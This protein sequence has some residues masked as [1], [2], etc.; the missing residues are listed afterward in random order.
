MML[1]FS[2][3]RTNKAVTN[4][5]YN[6]F[7][8]N[9]FDKVKKNVPL[10]VIDLNFFKDTTFRGQ[11]IGQ[12]FVSDVLK[13]SGV[14]VGFREVSAE[15]LGSKPAQTLLGL[16]WDEDLALGKKKKI[17]KQKFLEHFPDDATKKTKAMIPGFH[18]SDFVS[19]QMHDVLVVDYNNIPNESQTTPVNETKALS[20]QPSGRIISA[21]PAWAIIMKLAKDAVRVRADVNPFYVDRAILSPQLKADLDNLAA[22]FYKVCQ[23][24]KEDVDHPDVHQYRKNFHKFYESYAIEAKSGQNQLDAIRNEIEQSTESHR[25]SP[26]L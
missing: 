8:S 16:L 26:V 13:E 20:L 6:F 25:M 18:F 9:S 19:P 1:R 23:V 21:V 14:S 4:Q 12:N 5:K 17:T 22:E 3:L 2:L 10:R 7:H 24:V 11:P 15:E